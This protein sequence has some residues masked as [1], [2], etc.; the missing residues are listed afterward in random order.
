MTLGPAT[1]SPEVMRRLVDCGASL[2]RL[3]FSHGEVEEHASRLALVREV[4]RETGVPLGVLGDLPG[5]KIR[6]PISRSS[7]S[8]PL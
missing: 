8:R 5:P 7:S 3:N 2:F 1:A 6:M 4:E